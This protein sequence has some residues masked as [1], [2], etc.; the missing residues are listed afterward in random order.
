MKKMCAVFFVD[1]RI[2]FSSLK[3]EHQNEELKVLPQTVIKMDVL[4]SDRIDVL[5]SV[6]CKYLL[7]C[8]VSASWVVRIIRLKNHTKK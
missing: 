1:C 3:M 6:Y 4:A 8:Y 7:E 2:F 5:L